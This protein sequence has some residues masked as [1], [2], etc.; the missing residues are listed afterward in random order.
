[1][2]LLNIS[3]YT[4]SVI[5]FTFEDDP[6]DDLLIMLIKTNGREHVMPMGKKTITFPDATGTIDF[7]ACDKYKMRLEYVKPGCTYTFKKASSNQKSNVKLIGTRFYSYDPIPF[8][9]DE[10]KP[11]DEKTAEK[12]KLAAN[13]AANAAAAN[14]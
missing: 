11:S 6:E 14:K 3:S 9:V 2:M 1:M 8:I 10:Q 12:P 5:T 4:F 13:T 7:V